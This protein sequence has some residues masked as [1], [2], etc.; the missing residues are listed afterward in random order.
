M[1]SLEISKLTNAIS[2]PPVEKHCRNALAARQT[3][4]E[5]R[6]KFIKDHEEKNPNLE[7]NYQQAIG[8]KLIH[9]KIFKRIE[10]TIEYFC[11]HQHIFDLLFDANNLVECE[12]LIYRGLVNEEEIKVKKFD[13]ELNQPFLE[14]IFND[15][16]GLE[17]AHSKSFS[18]YQGTGKTYR[19]SSWSTAQVKSLL[20]LFLTSR[21]FLLPEKRTYHI[22]VKS[23]SYIESMFLFLPLGPNE[24]QLF[25]LILAQPHRFLLVVFI[26]S[27][28]RWSFSFCLNFCLPV[29]STISIFCQFIRLK[30]RFHFGF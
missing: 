30:K 20:N 18:T 26:S 10:T 17:K 9:G 22:R 28:F 7:K 16:I 23:S 27:F 12:T 15:W 19:H 8:S 11:G 6:R 2:Y 1:F 25:L 4:I 24:I 3:A 29:R 13:E 5:D 14:M 21:L